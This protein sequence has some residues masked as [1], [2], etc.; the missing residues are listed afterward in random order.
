[1]FAGSWVVSVVF[2]EKS[3]IYKVAPLIAISVLSWLFSPYN[4]FI[5][6]FVIL[7]NFIVSIIVIN[8]LNLPE[9]IALNQNLILGS[10]LFFC[11]YHIIFALVMMDIPSAQSVK[12]A[13]FVVG[14]VW[15]FISI[16]I[17]NIMNIT[18][19]AEN[20]ATTKKHL[21]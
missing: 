9:K 1:M 15:I 17:L 16:F 11:L 19:N 14:I 18:R 7:Y 4:I 5:T 10:C 3:N 13:I 12:P 2:A 6:I 8:R 21:S 20:G